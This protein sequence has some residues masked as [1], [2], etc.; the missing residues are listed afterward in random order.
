MNIGYASKTLGLP[1]GRMRSLA[2]RNAS[3]ER[4]AEA[5]GANLSALEAVIRYCGANG[6]RLF[7]VGSDVIAWTGRMRSGSGSR[8]SGRWPP[9]TRCGSACTRGRT[10]C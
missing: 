3:D 8:P 1:E 7:R 9:G 6:I 5:I 10:R 4:L 2:M